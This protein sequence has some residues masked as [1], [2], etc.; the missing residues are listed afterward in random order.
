MNSRT[1]IFLF[2]ILSAQCLIGQNIDLEELNKKQIEY[3]R[4]DTQPV[5]LTV[6]PH[7]INSPFSEYNGILYE[8]STFFFT[9]LRAESD[10][11]FQGLFDA[12]WSSYIYTCQ[13]NRGGYSKPVP[14]SF[15]INSRKYYNCNFTFN[16]KRDLLYFTRCIKDDNE[17]ELQCEIWKSNYEKGHWEKPKPLNRRINL[18]GTNTTQPFMVEYDDYHVLYFSSNRPKGY[19][20]NDIWYTV[21]QNDK[22]ND[23]INLGSNINTTG[24]EITPF[25]DK[26]NEVLYFSSDKHPGLGGYD[27]FYSFGA[28]N[29]WSS[30]TNM[31]VPFN[32]EYNDFYFSQNTHNTN[33]YLSSNRPWDTDDEVEEDTCCSDIFHYEWNGYFKEKEVVVE[34]TIPTIE[35]IQNI[36]PLTLYFHNDEPDP[37]SWESTTRANYRNTLADYIAKRKT[38]EEEYSKGLKGDEKEEAIQRIGRFFTDSIEQ[39]FIKLE[40]F[41]TYLQA[42]L[43]SGK[44][45]KITISGYAS[46]LH[47]AE[48]NMRLSSRRIASLKNYLQEYKNGIFLPYMTGKAKNKLEIH[49]NPQGQSTASKLVSN[50]INDKRNSVYSIAAS[51]ERRI[52]ITEYQSSQEN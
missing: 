5:T 15:V 16:K 8:D 10:A 6:L 25:Y 38:Y 1:L 19:G 33:G 4:C 2:L 23:P 37:R 24:N 48:Y 52:Q 9:S 40:L 39:G 36:L 32:S 50:N 47:K 41:A 45:V 12:Y 42:E 18:P 43:E 44:D 21:Y 11:D 7:I 31:G 14:F 3:I 30:P 34:D 26:K 20:G 22:Y 27:I 46:P 29:Q 49:E 13:L 35:K 51:L 17:H 28:F